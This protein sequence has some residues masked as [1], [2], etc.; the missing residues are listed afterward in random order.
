MSFRIF[1]SEAVVDTTTWM[2]SH[3]VNLGLNL[4]LA[5]EYISS[6]AF[7]N[8]AEQILRRKLKYKNRTEAQSWGVGIGVGVGVGRRK[9]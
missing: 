6:K 4:N 5:H 2:N 8:S 3:S 1:S 9:N 7:H